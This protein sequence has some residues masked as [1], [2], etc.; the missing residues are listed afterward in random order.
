MKVF[1]AG[2]AAQHFL[3]T[4]KPWND[5][6]RARRGKDAFQESPDRFGRGLWDLYLIHWLADGW[7]QAWGRLAGDLCPLPCQGHWRQ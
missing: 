1:A 6:I 5:D 2:K 7:Q 4:T 3:T